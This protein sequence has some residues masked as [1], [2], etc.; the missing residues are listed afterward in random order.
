MVSAAMQ[1]I[2]SQ[3]SA[4]STKDLSSFQK[5]NPGS[6]PDP[7]IQNNA[8]VK[9]MQ[10]GGYLKQQGGE[11]LLTGNVEVPTDL[12][13]FEEYY[14]MVEG[15]QHNT[16]EGKPADNIP[17]KPPT[18]E[19]RS[20][21]TNSSSDFDVE[22]YQDMMNNIMMPSNIRFDE[23]RSKGSKNSDAPRP[24]KPD[25]NSDP[26]FSMDTMKDILN[27]DYNSGMPDNL[28]Y[29][30]S[31]LDNDGIFGIAKLLAGTSLIGKGINDGIGPQNLMKNLENVLPK[32]FMGGI[33]SIGGAE[34]GMSSMSDISNMGVDMMKDMGTDM[35][36][37]MGDQVSSITDVGSN[38]DG[39]AMKP[40]VGNVQPDSS[41]MDNQPSPDGPTV[42]S[43]KKEDGS[44]ESDIKTQQFMD[45]G[46]SKID[47]ANKTLQP[48][49]KPGDISPSDVT[50]A[51]Q[52]EASSFV[53]ESGKGVAKPEESFWDKMK[54][55]EGSGGG[56]G[57]GGQSPGEDIVAGMSMMND[58]LEAKRRKKWEAGRNVGNTMT[59]F[60]G[61]DSA[62]PYG[63]Y[64]TN[65]GPASNF[66]LVTNTPPQ[67]LGYAERGGLVKGKEMLVDK[68]MLDRIIQ[69]GGEV[70]IITDYTKM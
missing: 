60:M 50:T 36:S 21:D 10:D 59:D 19:S 47:A 52:G 64:T 46:Q 41:F 70:E 4:N 57:G 35:M 20:I 7:K 33:S 62:N 26:K 39:E 37:K 32:K 31:A 6:K 16:M 65:A 43:A 2:K 69:M 58:W 5:S 45:K 56:G 48:G 28:A 53:P 38:I 51:K 23:A 3:N 44:L 24:T 54:K 9:F 11:K 55:N 25:E 34:M 67:D 63:N 12:T 13:S 27:R 22:A 49:Y 66:Q 68:E 30:G 8:L 61:Y 40:E 15:A 17:L 42:E 29:L 1:Q 18:M 14:K